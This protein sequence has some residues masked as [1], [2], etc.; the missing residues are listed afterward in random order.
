MRT[1]ER[2]EAEETFET[3]GLWT[4]ARITVCR[5]CSRYRPTDEDR[6][7]RRCA[8]ETAVVSQLLD[9]FE[10]VADDLAYYDTSER[11]A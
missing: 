11:V 3:A 1:S 5:W 10:P 7:C 8:F 9:T 6:T 4:V 2:I